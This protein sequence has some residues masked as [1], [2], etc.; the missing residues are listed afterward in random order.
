M[1]R[2]WVRYLRANSEAKADFQSWV[3][4]ELA[5]LSVVVE[6][7]LIANDHA[8]ATRKAIEKQALRALARPVEKA[9]AVER[10]S[11]DHARRTSAAKRAY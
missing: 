11:I 7:S 3:A 5:R 10:E 6:D 1:D 9:D 4:D 8:T 2:L